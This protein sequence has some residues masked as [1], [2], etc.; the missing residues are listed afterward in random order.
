MVQTPAVPSSIDQPVRVRAGFSLTFDVPYP[1]PMLFVVQPVDRL[2]PTGTRQRI[3]DERPLGAAQGIHSYTDIHGNRVWRTLAQPGE[4][5]V[6]HDLIA[7]VT[8]RPDPILPDLPKHR[9]EDLPDETIQYLLPS[10]YVDSDLVSGEAW[11]RFGHIAGGWAQ[12]QAIS[13]FLHD[14]CVYGSGSTSTTT[15]RQALDSKRAVCRD[16]AHMGVAFCRALNIP[17]RYVCGY[18]PDID[19]TPDP[20]P[21]D[22]HAWFEA[23]LGG[24]WR[25]FDARH[26]KPRA[27]RL[28]IAQ[29][30]DA[31]D[32]AFTTTF[33]AARLTHM[34]VWADETGEGTT[35]DDPPKPRVF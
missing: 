7:E 29:G 20:V 14:E 17:A 3:V 2:Y 23:Y 18:L 5:T 25:T 27:G 30:R 28:L 34:K 19:I 6:G 12:V 13:D 11:E 31:S 22:F 21:M 8:R 15:A 33:G 24:E 10:R 4:F 16:F 35:L 1:T 9:V 32:V 26:N